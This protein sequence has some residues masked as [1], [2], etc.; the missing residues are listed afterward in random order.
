VP[1]AAQ[2]SAPNSKTTAGASF[3]ELGLQAALEQANS[4]RNGEQCNI[5][6]AL[7][8]ADYGHKLDFDTDMVRERPPV[9]KEFVQF[10][11]NV[12]RSVR[13]YY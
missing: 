10:V 12:G 13:R 7:S 11:P 2:R 4:W 1:R 5:V 9:H 6:H 8:T 3:G